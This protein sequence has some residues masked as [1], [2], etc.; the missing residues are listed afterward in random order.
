MYKIEGFTGQY[1]FLSNFAPAQVWYDGLMYPSVEHAYQAA[2]TTV[3][4]ERLDIQACVKPGDAKK[5]GKEVTLRPDW[6]KVR[7]NI[8]AYLVRQK[9]ANNPLKQML[10]DTKDYELIETNSWGDTFWGVCKGVGSNHLG[11][12]LMNVRRSLS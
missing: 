4:S 8:M 9:F 10:L 11:K 5:A 7:L 2:K 12:I 1:R 3:S 6:E